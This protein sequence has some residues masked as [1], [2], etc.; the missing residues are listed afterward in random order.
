MKKN[1]FPATTACMAMPPNP[2][3]AAIS[4]RIKNAAGHR[5]IYFDFN[6]LKKCFS[7]HIVK[8]CATHNAG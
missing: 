4:A 3:T 1:T 7:L 6:Y 8:Y 5:N 2:S